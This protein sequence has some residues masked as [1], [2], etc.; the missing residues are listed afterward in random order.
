MKTATAVRLARAAARKIAR[1]GLVLS[2]VSI[3]AA[4]RRCPAATGG[5]LSDYV[6]FGGHQVTIS[7]SIN[8]FNAPL[9]LVGSNGDIS[10][11]S[12]T[13]RG[14]Q[15]VA[16]GS[17]VGN[18][19]FLTAN[20]LI[21]NGNVQFGGLTNI[22]GDV[23]AGGTANI[24]AIGRDVAPGHGAVTVGGT[25]NGN[26]ATNNSV[27]LPTF[28]QV[29]GNVQ[30]A[31]DVTMQSSTTIQGNVTYGGTLS[32]SGLTTIGGTMTHAPSSASPISFSPLSI[33][34]STFSAG[35][36]DISIPVFGMAAPAP[37]SYGAVSIDGGTLELSPG[38]YFFNSVVATSGF[39]NLNLRL[40]K[41]GD[42]ELY[43][44]GDYN[45]PLQVTEVNG[46][47]ISAADAA[48]A[49]RV[50]VES[51]G[52]VFVGWDNL[53]TLYAPAGDVALDSLT[54]L[55]GQVIAGHDAIF[56]GGADVQFVASAHLPSAVPEPGTIL[57]AAVGV[58][59]VAVARFGR[60]SGARTRRSVAW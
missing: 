47:A 35:G 31:Q 43:V 16:G 52:N 28:G 15:F 45:I 17:L 22:S 3:A 20:S 23:D 19:S 33:P 11:D 58:T 7:S 8:V 50:F 48:L 32:R 1:V 25:V 51:H 4:N 18:P 24:G 27:T 53:G 59:L 10:L 56:G 36:P 13:V 40:D 9:A 57:L 6:V 12:G 42:I 41:P 21:F 37:G 26:V 44:L 54:D 60:R 38:K 49:S 5:G 14:T 39:M 34:A 55:W 30:A 2:L 29:N 46:V